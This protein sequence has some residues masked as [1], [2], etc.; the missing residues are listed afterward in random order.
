MS[1]EASN[2]WLLVYALA[3]QELPGVDR[4]AFDVLPLPLGK[5]RVES[6]RT[7]ARS[8]RAGDDDKL[9]ARNVEI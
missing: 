1:F 6:Q 7:F 4:E 3:M 8:A 9:V 5:Q 2:S